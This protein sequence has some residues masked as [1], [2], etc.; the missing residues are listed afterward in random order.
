MAGVL[1]AS[2]IHRDSEIMGNS[3]ASS[4]APLT[5]VETPGAVDVGPEQPSQQVRS[6]HFAVTWVTLFAHLDPIEASGPSEVSASASPRTRVEHPAPSLAL[7][8][9]VAAPL[10]EQRTT[11][12]FSASWEMVVP[13]M[14]RTSA[15]TF[16]PAESSERNSKKPE[17][18]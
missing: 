14:I 15:R 5:A 2:D 13:K 4:V 8:P 7:V 10:M 6:F 12:Q 11:E 1:W 17:L 9:V 18:V 16:L 3:M